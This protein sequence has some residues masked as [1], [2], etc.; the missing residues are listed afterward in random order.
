[1]SSPLK[2]NQFLRQ[3]SSQFRR[4][5]N[6]LNQLL[7]SDAELLQLPDGST[8]AVTTDCIAEEISTGL[9]SDPA[10]IGWMT[11]VVNLSDLS[12][13]G[14]QPLGLLL[15]ES[16]PAGFPTEK[17]LEL[18]RGI[19]AACDALGVCVLGGDTNTGCWQMGGT[20]VG[21]IPAGEKR[22][23][24]KGAKAGHLLYASGRM[25]LGSAYAFSVLFGAS[26]AA[27]NYQPLPRLE[28]GTLVRKWGSSC[29]D[30]S[31]GFFHALSN[32]MEVNAIGFRLETPM[33]EF[34]HPEA[35]RICQSSQLP[36]WIFL[37]GP[38]G[39]FELVF[40][41]PPEHETAFLTAASNIGWTPIKIGVCTEG[42]H[43]A[44]QTTSGTDL[45]IL[46]TTIANAFTEAGGDPKVFLQNLLN[47]E[48][49][50]QIQQKTG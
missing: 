38:H 44:L 17:L 49:T 4:A 10:H 34:A 28:A 24:R 14:A 22:I 29:I 40:T 8:L 42:E 35:L 1:M 27:V 13:V 32:I 18:Q 11:V 46:P 33:A 25:G 26:G 20:A 43:C 50:W 2:E 23:S 6:Q 19:A 21:I 48:S 30:T 3:I 36:L 16:L 7:E 5:P 12:A 39:E 41:L 31:D 47:L 37:A 45:L 15:S 9:Y